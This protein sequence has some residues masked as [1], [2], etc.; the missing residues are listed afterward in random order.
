MQP[1]SNFLDLITQLTFF[2]SKIHELLGNQLD[3]NKASPKKRGTKKKPKKKILRSI[4]IES[5]K[6]KNMLRGCR[7]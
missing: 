3:N 6:R 1:V 2:F 7:L 5:I 4:I